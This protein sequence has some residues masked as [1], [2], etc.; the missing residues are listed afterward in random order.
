MLAY[1]RLERDI[2]DPLA[3]ARTAANLKALRASLAKRIPRQTTDETL[4]LGTWN[5]RNFDDNRFGHGPR[6]AESFFYI[7]E[8][9]AAFDIIAI[10]EL[11]V[12]LDPL[13][14]LMDILG[15]DYRYLITDATEGVAGN[16]ERLGFIYN[17]RKVQFKGVAGEIVLPENLMIS[18]ENQKMQFSR[19]PFCASF[20]AGWFNFMFATVHIYYGSGT[21]NSIQYQ[22][23]LNEIQTIANFLFKRAA[24]ERNNYILVG[25]FN[26]DAIDDQAYDALE[27]SGFSVFKNREGSNKRQNK[28]FDQISYVEK[29]GEV[30]LAECL[31][32]GVESNGVYNFFDVLFTDAQFEDYDSALQATLDQQRQGVQKAN[33]IAKLEALKS[34]K[35]ARLNYYRNDWKTFQ[36]SDHYPLWVTLTVD[37][38]DRYLTG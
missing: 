38:S 31:A 9:I 12:N 25:D 19:T 8:I 1:W 6:L 27:E 2:E 17:T 37:F 4:I 36:I 21:K 11:T 18:R 29:P 7:A 23:R 15:P 30:T 26:I 13:E 28:F 33:D 10:Q 35:N 3:R 24:N 32:E 34:D 22:T 5:I 16:N 14:R 20:Q